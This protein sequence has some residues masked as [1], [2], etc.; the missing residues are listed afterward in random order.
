[1]VD[2]SYMIRRPQERH[3]SGAAWK[4]GALGPYGAGPPRPP[5]FSVEEVVEFSPLQVL[6]WAGSVLL[7]GLLIL[8]V[9][10]W[11]LVRFIERRLKGW[12]TAVERVVKS[13]TPP[14]ATP[15]ATVSVRKQL[16]SIRQLD[17]DF[18]VVL[19]EDF[20]YALYTEAQTAR[21]QGATARLAPYLRAAARAQLDALGAYPVS[22]IV[23][24]AM[25]FVSFS[26]GPRLGLSVELEAN[27]AEEHEGGSHGTYTRERWILSRTPAARSRPPDKVR[28]LGCPACG[29]PLDRLLGG[30]CPHCARVVDGGNHDWIVESIEMLERGS[31]GPMLTGTVEEEGTELPTVVDPHLM[32]EL[33]SLRARDP[34]FDVVRFRGRIQLIFHVMQEAWSTLRWEKAR[35]YLTDNLFEAQSYWIAAYRQQG[36]RN[37][38][39]HAAIR[40]IELA[41]ITQDRWYCAVTV[42]LHAGSLDYTLRDRDGHVVGGDI[43]RMRFYTEYWTL[44]RGTGSTGTTRSDPSCPSCGAPLEVSMAARCAYCRAKVNSGEFDWV[45]SRIEQDE[46]YAG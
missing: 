3:A 24:G 22:G 18:S 29:A 13:F 37:I 32:Q 31:R 17:P 6:V 43:N 46:V 11:L 8:L 34:A 10:L 41:R 20:L 15:A 36:L 30:T 7:V 14:G 44:I 16:D 38:T 39:A 45:L 23:V 35:P 33:A 25:R 19:L 1:M 26:P 42:R 40:N 12:T 28:A 21:G 9:L 27:Y 2:V 5:G 4:P